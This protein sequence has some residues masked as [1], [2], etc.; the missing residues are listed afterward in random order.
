MTA[1]FDALA[2]VE[3]LAEE[4]R[5]AI[6]EIVRC[7][8]RT[9]AGRHDAG[10]PP[11]R[12]SSPRGAVRFATTALERVA[13]IVAS[14]VLSVGLIGLLSGFFAGTDPAGMSGAATHRS[15]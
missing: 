9:A 15:G 12:R 7:G 2:D 8:G 14:L 4:L 13:I 6:E 3:V 5:G 10:P 1:D 11:P